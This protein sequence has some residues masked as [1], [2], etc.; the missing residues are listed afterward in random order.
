[1]P[2]ENRP[3]DELLRAT[4]FAT[5]ADITLRLSDLAAGIRPRNP[6][7]VESPSRALQALC[8]IL[9]NQPGLR[10]DFRSALTNFVASRKAVSFYADAGM[11]P[12]RGF[13]AETMRR[14]SRSLLP[15]DADILYLKDVVGVIF[16]RKTDAHWISAIPDSHWADLLLALRFDEHDAGTHATTLVDEICESLRIISYRIAAIGLEPEL[17]RVEPALEKFES[18]F[19]TQN[20]EIL[21]YLADYRAWLRGNGRA[22]DDAHLGA[23]LD[24]GRALMERVRAQASR[25]GT[26]LSLTLLLTRIGQHLNR[27]EALLAVLGSFARRRSVDDVVPSLV[28]LIKRLIAD[29]CRKN[30]VSEFWSANLDIL[31]RR[32]TDNASRTGEHY[33][34]SDRSGYLAMLRSASLGGVIIAFM[35]LSQLL[36]LDAH[37]PPLTEALAVCLNYGIGFVIIHILHGTVATKQPAMTAATIA[38][39]MDRTNEESSLNHLA[40]LIARTARSQLVAILGN[41]SVA[42]PMA[43][44]LGLGLNLALGHPYPSPEKSTAHTRQYPSLAQ[45]FFGVCGNRRS[46]PFSRGTDFGL[47]RQSRRL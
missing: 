41:V 45:R 27:C 2:Q 6:R 5:H 25:N 35:A 14:I 16:D 17:L 31:A 46:L 3:L 44:L 8:H 13:F 18:P 24:Q 34:T 15:D 23:L 22:V 10:A 7:D 33:I 42:L 9:R 12:N 21:R 39:S 43:I 1:M 30:D 20:P 11:F 37:L 26:S 38:A 28:V 36:I 47:L 40:A 29:E 19:L 32:V 4:A